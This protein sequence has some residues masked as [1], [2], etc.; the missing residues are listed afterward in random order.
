ME[1]LNAAQEA[2]PAITKVR[3]AEHCRRDHHHVTKYI[4][5]GMRFLS[6]EKDPLSANSGRVCAMHPGEGT[7]SFHPYIDEE[8]QSTSS[9]V[10][11]S[12]LI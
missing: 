10:G 4:A 12:K 5:T 2:S 3:A 8:N 1:L 6:Q 11:D 9:W 7:L